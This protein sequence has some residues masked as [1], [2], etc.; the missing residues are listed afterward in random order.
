MGDSSNE[1]SHAHG[2]FDGDTELRR[3]RTDR[4]DLCS[5]KFCIVTTGCLSSANTPDFEGSVFHWGPTPDDI[6]G[7]T[8]EREDIRHS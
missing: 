7:D 6:I 8:H 4:G 5:A 1:T 2:H 3:I